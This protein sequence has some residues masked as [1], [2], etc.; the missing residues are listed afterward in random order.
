MSAASWLPGLRVNLMYLMSAQT[1]RPDTDHSHDTG[2]IP[3]KNA[4]MKK[5]GLELLKNKKLII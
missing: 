5:V 2:Q 4:F 1:S 3:E